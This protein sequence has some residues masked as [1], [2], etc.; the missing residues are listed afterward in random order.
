MAQL[1]SL[2]QPFGSP[3]QLFNIPAPVGIEQAG[4]FPGL[5]Q[6]A[7]SIAAALIQRDLQE[8][9]QSDFALLAQVLN[10]QQQSLALSDP[11]A[12]P[13][14]LQ[15][16]TPQPDLSQ[17]AGLQ[18]PGAQQFASQ[19]FGQQLQRQ[20]LPPVSGAPGSQLRDPLTGE[21]IG[22][23]VPFQSRVPIKA[24]E[25]ISQKKLDRINQ[26]QEKV[27]S[28]T[29]TSKDEAL[30][31]KMLAG[32]SP[33]QINFGRTTGA[34]RTAIAETEASL[35]ILDNLETLFNNPN[36]RTG[37]LAGRIDPIKGLVGFTSEEQE[38]FMAATSAFTNQVIKAI[39]GAQMSEVEA[40]RIR[41]QI[42]EITDPPARWRAK[43]KQTRRNLREL[44]RKRSEVLTRSGIVSPLT[45]LT[46]DLRNVGRE[47][48]L[49]GLGSPQQSSPPRQSLTPAD[50]D[51]LTLEQLQNL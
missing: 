24:S 47:A 50:L 7:N 40:K 41:K 49:P 17:L 39:T 22:E 10:P 1:R 51:N 35:S 12:G 19:L 21:L 46:E 8:K 34:E 38:N 36:T 9:Q 29:A 6:G 32:V 42:P 13:P 37:P 23:P 14:G 15:Q 18:T 2:G 11:N 31:D 27:A 20:N 43:L 45:G 30:L 25:K 48:G 28:G 44:Q 16:F 3:S 33:V 26:L 5:Q 4:R